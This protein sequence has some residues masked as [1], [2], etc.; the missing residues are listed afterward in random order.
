MIFKI[1]SALSLWMW[2]VVF[3]VSEVHATSIFRVKDGGRIYFL[4]ISDTAHK[5]T[6]QKLKNGIGINSE[7]PW[8]TKMSKI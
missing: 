3:T 2:T 8:K 6:A 5:H 7:P 4:D 1:L